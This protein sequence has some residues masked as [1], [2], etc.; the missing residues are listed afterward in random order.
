MSGASRRRVP[1]L[2]VGATYRELKDELDKAYRRVMEGGWYVLGA[3]LDS[4]EAEFAAYCEASQCVGVAN[5]L[6]A[7]FLI[8]RGYSIGGSDEVIVPANTF[9][10][11]WLAVSHSGAIPVLVEPEETRFNLD[12]DRIAAA[13]TSRTRAIF[14]VHLY[15]QPARMDEMREV[16]E[17]RG[18]RVIEDAAQAHGARWNGERTG[19]LAD[20]AASFGRVRGPRM[21]ARRLS[22]YGAV[23]GHGLEF[24]DGASP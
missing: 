6:E 22:N 18:L 11:T 4:F 14:A 8:L 1:F 9:I 3:E 10:A 17:R 7:L 5:G 15:G 19:S 12:P 23:G 2:D 13:V 21:A 20:A 24:A 16:A